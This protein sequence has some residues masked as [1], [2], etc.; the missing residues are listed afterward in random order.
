MSVK[1]N[2]GITKLIL[3]FDGEEG[4]RRVGADEDLIQVLEPH[5]NLEELNVEY[6]NGKIFSPRWMLSL[7]NLKLVSLRYGIHCERLPPSLGKLPC[8]ESIDL[9]DF[10]QLKRVGA[11]FWGIQE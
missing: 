2:S 1:V 10:T 9:I 5:P 7:A 11:E 8:L 4:E 6:Y 3:C